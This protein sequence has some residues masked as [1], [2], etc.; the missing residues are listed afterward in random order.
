MDNELNISKEMNKNLS[1][2]AEQMIS[3]RE[4]LAKGGFSTSEASNAAF[5]VMHAVLHAE[6]VYVQE[7]ILYRFGKNKG[8]KS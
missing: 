2:L 5:A 1:V 7:K 6:G 8:D 3:F 4:T